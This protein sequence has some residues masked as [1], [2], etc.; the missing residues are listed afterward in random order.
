MGTKKKIKI[1]PVDRAFII[2]NTIFMILFVFIT[3]YPILNTLALA[4]NE[5]LSK[6]MCKQ[7][8]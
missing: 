4:F 5:G 2:C 7:I 3:L 6:K 1:S 8:I